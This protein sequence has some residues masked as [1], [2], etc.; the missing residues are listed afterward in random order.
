MGFFSS[1]GKVVSAPFKATKALVTGGSVS[2]A[3]G[4]KGD[5]ST[6]DLETGAVSQATSS[7]EDT[8]GSMDDK[9]TSAK[10]KTKRGKKALKVALNDEEDKTSKKGL[11]I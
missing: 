9:E 8:H 10:K 1:I 3:L 5:S 11:N 4:L 6:A 2:E 7:G